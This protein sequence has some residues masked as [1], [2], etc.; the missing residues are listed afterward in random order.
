MYGP[1]YVSVMLSV[2]VTLKYGV[3]AVAFIITEFLKCFHL[4]N[5]QK[6]N[7][8]NEI[9]LHLT[10]FEINQ[11]L[12]GVLLDIPRLS[13]FGKNINTDHKWILNITLL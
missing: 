8:G 5:T 6:R 10:N 12:L 1:N 3:D 2:N 13:F 9:R 4:E 11:S 7:K